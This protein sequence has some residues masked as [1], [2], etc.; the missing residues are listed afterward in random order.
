[1]S[2][3]R[4]FNKHHGCDYEGRRTPFTGGGGGG[5]STT[6]SETTN[7]PDYAR[8]YVE[9]M[10][11]ATQRQLF[12][13]G[14]T[15]GTPAQYDEQGNM[16]AP[17]TPGTEQI[18]GFKPYKPYSTNVSD[19]FAEASPLQK[20]SYQGMANMKVAPQIGEG[21]VMANQGGA[22]LMATAV[23]AMGIAGR[24][25]GTGADYARMATDP[26]AISSY[27]SPYMQNV[28]NY[29]KGQA[30]RD[31]QM[32]QPMMQAKAAGQGAFGGNRLA[33]QQAE[34]QRGLMSQLQGIEASGA[35]NAFQNAQQAQQFGANLGLQGLQTGLQG[36]GAAQA[37]LTG[38]LNAANT[39]GNLGQ[40]QYS[41]QMG[42]LQGQNQFG[43]QQQQMEQAKINQAISD[44][45]TAQQ[46]PYMQLGMMSKMLRGLPMQQMTTQSYQNPSAISQLGGLA[47]TGIG[48][49]GAAGG[50]R[51][52]KAGGSV[53][54]KKY[55]G[56]QG[57]LVD[58]LDVITSA[59]ADLEDKTPQELDR[60]VKT[61]R[62]NM[63]REK[64]RE[65]LAEKISAA[66]AQQSMGL[67]SAPAPN[68]D[69][70]ATMAGGGIVAFA[71]NTGSRVKDPDL[72][73]GGEDTVSR[74]LEKFGYGKPS[75]ETEALKA[76][77]TQA[78]ED[79]KD[80]QDQNFWR[81]L[82]MGGAKTMGSTSPNPF[83][84]F[85][86]GIQ[87]GLGTYAKGEKDYGD[88]LN[89][90]RT[91]EI[92]IAK[93]NAADRNH[94]LERAL[95]ATRIEEEAKTRRQVAADAAAARALTAG[96]GKTD[97]MDKL[98]QTQYATIAKNAADKLG[99]TQPSEEQRQAWLKEAISDV[100]Y[101]LEAQG[102]PGLSG[103]KDKGGA[104]GTNTAG[105][106]PTTEEEYN[107]LP[108]GAHYI[109]PNGKT[110]IKG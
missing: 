66:K 63:L 61:S 70:M 17:A 92:D 107:K 108:K 57:S 50:F 105:A 83:V 75:E 80:A 11:G 52:Y 24:A 34:A 93:L 29:Q 99:I 76:Q 39:L 58:G 86:E 74:Y 56:N 73:M 9:N 12:N 48:A 30:L 54:T 20:M 97:R 27:M 2:I 28:V 14:T 43:L 42:I 1:M 94:I 77:Q 69:G 89:K 25:A 41:Q 106:K 44:Y 35:Q 23:P 51:G 102:K 81:A 68:M 7:I 47:A 53:Q 72:Q 65:I 6:K 95:G 31:F 33:L 10:L 46:Y 40:N 38:G 79:I 78:R 49:Y 62:S 32:G 13:V 60:I 8:P 98:I 91:G 45:A 18:T 101:M 55:A 19:Y 59:E 90:I 71:G 96:L 84:G 26:N 82:M 103:A 5:P 37:G 67:A 64:A 87:E 104:G 88:M 4:H 110:R 21:S 22:G 36:I 15:G 100:N 3:L 85:S 16:I 109:D